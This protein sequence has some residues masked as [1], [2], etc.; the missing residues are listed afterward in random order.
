MLANIAPPASATPS[1]PKPQRSA[2][3]V[4]KR[5]RAALD[6]EDDFQDPDATFPVSDGLRASATLG[7]DDIFRVLETELSEPIKLS[8]QANNIAEVFEVALIESTVAD[9][10]GDGLMKELQIEFVPVLAADGRSVVM[11]VC[12]V[13]Q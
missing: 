4:Q 12:R 2:E 7:S 1:T 6:P 8:N 3:A 13:T 10:L 5:L 9:A 11:H